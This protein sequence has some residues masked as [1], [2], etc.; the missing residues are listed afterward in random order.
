MVISAGSPLGDPE[1]CTQKQISL[2][3]SQRLLAAHFSRPS[4]DKTVERAALDQEQKN[5][6]RYLKSFLCNVAKNKPK[7]FVTVKTI[8][9]RYI[10]HQ[11]RS[12]QVPPLQLVKNIMN[13]EEDKKHSGFDEKVKPHAVIKSV[14][15]GSYCHGKGKTAI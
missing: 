10:P 9:N 14:I 7:A 13:C 8:S 12:L 15:Q 4:L 2:V 6:N 5:R 11:K 1:A 3:L